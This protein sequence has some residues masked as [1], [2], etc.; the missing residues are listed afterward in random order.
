MAFTIVIHGGAG[1]ILRK[2][3]TPE[4]EKRYVLALQQS[5]DAGYKALLSGKSAIDAA[6]ASVISLEDNIL[7]NAGRGSVFNN[8][9]QH[10]MDAAL[11]D[12]A[13]HAL[14]VT[15]SSYTAGRHITFFQTEADIEPW[16]RSQRLA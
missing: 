4:L 8:E 5:L 11:M 2:D 6:E 9:G 10:E 3:M 12:G 7:F 1:T 13:L 14:A 16:V 15:A